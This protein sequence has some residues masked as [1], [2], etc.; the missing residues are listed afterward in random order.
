MWLVCVLSKQLS[1]IWF[2]ALQESHSDPSWAFLFE[3]L[4][5]GKAGTYSP[6]RL[7]IPGQVPALSIFVIQ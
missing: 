3:R 7:A 1:R 4:A 6:F 2:S 5:K